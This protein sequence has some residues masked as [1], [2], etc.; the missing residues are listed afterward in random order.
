M[1]KIEKIDYDSVPKHTPTMREHAQA[2]NDQLT[3]A[4]QSIGNMHNYWYGKRYNKLV[5]EFNKLIPTFS[6]ILELIVGEIPFTLET[7]ANN[8]SQ[9]DQ[10]TKVTNAVKTAPAKITAIA[11]L[12]DIGMKFITSEV[13]KVKTDVSKNFKAAIDKMNNYETEYKKIYWESEAAEVFANKIRKSKENIV[14]AFGDIE[15]QFTTLMTQTLAD[16]QATENANTVQ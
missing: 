9:A 2:V 6:D 1:A 10:G 12:N 8:Y 13:E 7:V 4:Y 11:I 14:K 16:V 5:E 3:A 15:S